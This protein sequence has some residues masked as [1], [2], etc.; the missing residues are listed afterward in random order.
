MNSR[1]LPGIFGLLLFL[2]L[3]I[4]PIAFSLGYAAFYSLGLTGLLS[5][6]FTWNH[7]HT[8]FSEQEVWSSLGLS[9]YISGITVVLT[10]IISIALSLYLRRPLSRGTL[11]S[12]IYLPLAIPATVAA[13]LV[14]QLLS[15]AGFVSRIAMSTGL[16]A[17]ISE[18]PDFINDAAGI[19]I[20]AAH[21][22]LAIPFFTIFFHEIYTRERIDA[23]SQVAHTLGASG[24][25]TLFSVSLPILIK[26]GAL[27][28]AL[29]FIVVMG[30]YEI[31]LLLGRQSPQMISVLTL[32][33]YEMFDISEKPEAFI[34]AIL[35][36]LFVLVL[37]T[38]VFR[39][40]GGKHA[41]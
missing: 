13:F 26:R 10:V 9:V 12:L 20:I 19:G 7:W 36:T 5:E 22:G 28:I 4:L 18:F 25:D 2:I 32:R 40:T 39:R 6:G 3:A 21:T 23:L 37:L 41:I 15:G 31:P 38:V 14:F 30:S 35:Y 16:I 27:N 33:K 8:V 17:S 24:R 29:L 1:T 11:S 34:A